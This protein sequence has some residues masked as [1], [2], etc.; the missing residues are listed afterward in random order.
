[1]NA[2]PGF[3]FGQ[4]A[5]VG[6][7]VTITRNAADPASE[8]HLPVGPVA[9]AAVGH[10]GVAAVAIALGIAG[11][12]VFPVLIR[13]PGRTIDPAGFVVFDQV[14]RARAGA[15]IEHRMQEMR[16]LGLN[17]AGPGVEPRSVIGRA[18]R[19]VE[20]LKIHHR[21]ERFAVGGDVSAG[22]TPEVIG[23][24]GGTVNVGVGEMIGAHLHPG[25]LAVVH[26]AVEVCVLVVISFRGLRK[27]PLGIVGVHAGPVDRSL[28]ARYVDAK[29]VVGLSGIAGQRHGNN[30][31]GNLGWEN[32]FVCFRFSCSFLCGTT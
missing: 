21:I 9:R 23:I 26:V 19:A 16:G 17:I 27:R 8:R 11:V 14:A 4:C 28:V 12:Q 1:M 32:G 25:R 7:K 31:G 5:V 29:R 24:C 15:A 18:G 3:Q 10:P 13:N 30:A 6:V 2:L 22:E 20:G